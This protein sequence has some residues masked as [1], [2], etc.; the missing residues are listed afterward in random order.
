[1]GTQL[2]QPIKLLDITPGAVIFT[3]FTQVNFTAEGDRGPT[4][5]QQMNI[6]NPSSVTWEGNVLSNIEK[7]A[8]GDV[9]IEYVNKKR[10]VVLSWQFLT[11]EEYSRLLA[12]LQIDFRSN[13]QDVLFYR[14]SALSPNTTGQSGGNPNVEHIVAYLDGKHSGTIEAYT[15]DEDLVLG[16]RNVSLTFNER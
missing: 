10:K 7:N 15:V 9:F 8:K 12:Y 5:L 1:M 16:Y 13:R 6:P 3:G 2:N 14:I 4:S 11:Q